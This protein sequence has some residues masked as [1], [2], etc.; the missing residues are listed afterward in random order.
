MKK[1]TISRRPIVA[2]LRNGIRDKTIIR[3]LLYQIRAETSKHKKDPEAAMQQG[4]FF[5]V[6]CK[7]DRVT[8]YLFCTSKMNWVN[9]ARTE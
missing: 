5:S 3:I 4:Y 9:S 6:T 8:Q 7:T 2:L 1:A